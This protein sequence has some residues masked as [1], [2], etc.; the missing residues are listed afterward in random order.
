[1][2]GNVSVNCLLLVSRTF[3]TFLFTAHVRTFFCR[4]GPSVKEGGGILKTPATPGYS[5]RPGLARPPTLQVLL[6]LFFSTKASRS[7]CL[8]LTKAAFPIQVD[9]AFTERKT[10]AQRHLITISVLQ[11]GCGRAANPRC[12]ASV[13]SIITGWEYLSAQGFCDFPFPSTKSKSASHGRKEYI[14]T[15]HGILGSRSESFAWLFNM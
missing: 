13:L 9:L 7:L 5:R 12:P 2:L 8:V 10:E 3:N 6:L 4:L 15:A 11:L 1:M 14:A